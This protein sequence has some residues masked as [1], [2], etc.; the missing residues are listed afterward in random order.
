MSMDRE[1]PAHMSTKVQ[2]KVLVFPWV[3]A[4][5]RSET[6]ATSG[7]N[8]FQLCFRMNLGPGRVRSILQGQS[9]TRPVYTYSLVLS[10]SMNRVSWGAVNFIFKRGRVW[11]FMYADPVVS[12][13]H[14]EAFVFTMFAMGKYLKQISRMVCTHQCKNTSK[15]SGLC[16]EGVAQCCRN[17]LFTLAMSEN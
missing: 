9:Q 16:W 12:P 15:C 8:Q 11:R 1:F 3:K 2:N 17:Y 7:F 13:G 10:M 6:R 14:H 5:R 4:R